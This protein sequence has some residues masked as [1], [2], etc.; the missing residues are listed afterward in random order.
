M[1]C[2]IVTGAAQGIGYSIAE[3]LGKRGQ[4]VVIAGRTPAKVERAQEGLS[5][6]GLS[7]TGVVAD[8]RSEEDVVRMID[9]AVDRYGGV[10]ALINNAG[11]Y[12][13]RHI[14]D[15]TVEFW[16]ETMAINLRGAMLCAREAAKHMDET[17]RIVNV[18]SMSGVI[19]ERGFAAYNASKAGLMSLTKSLAVDLADRG[20]MVNCAAPGWVTTPM[21]E[22]YIASVKPEVMQKINLVGRA[23]TSDE[24]AEIV[25]FLARPEI[26]YLTGQTLIVDGGQTVWALLPEDVS[27]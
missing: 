18:S 22:D 4:P 24:I 14:L 27:R 2:A 11:V 16:D 1:T 10:Q 25:A 19:C 7:A 23:A 15:M 21:T 5:K 12:Q 9:T 13:E 26:S 3:C 8:V 17:G 20:I 6:Q